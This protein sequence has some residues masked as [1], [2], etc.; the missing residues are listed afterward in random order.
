MIMIIIHELEYGT[1]KSA[2]Y[3]SIFNRYDFII[4]TECFV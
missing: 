4:F 3:C 1:A 2:H